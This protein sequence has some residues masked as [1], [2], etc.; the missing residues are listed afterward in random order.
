MEV[1]MSTTEGELDKLRGEIQKLRSDLEHLGTTI[2]R[3]A[4]V[5]VRE[6][7]ESACDATENIRREWQKA[8]GRV[9]DKIEDNPV[10]ASLAA[11]GLGMLLG[12]LFS[13]NRG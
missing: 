13:S 5:G 8:A 9:T 4:K 1:L 6:A 12:R 7:G 10:G 11:L 3:A 2:G